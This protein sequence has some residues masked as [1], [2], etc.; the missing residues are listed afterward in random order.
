MLSVDR[1]QGYDNDGPLLHRHD[2]FRPPCGYIVQISSTM[3]VI[4]Q[5]ESEIESHKSTLSSQLVPLGYWNVNF[6]AIKKT[7]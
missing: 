5:D 3:Q 2:L 6:I 4:N 7:I 1:M